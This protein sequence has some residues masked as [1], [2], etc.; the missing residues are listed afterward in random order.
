[1]SE[2][3][4]YPVPN[5]LE[6]V[7][8]DGP[9]TEFLLSDADERLARLADDIALL[10][11]DRVAVLATWADQAD[12]VLWAGRD[13]VAGP[14]TVVL[15]VAEAAGMEAV[16]SVARGICILLDDAEEGAG[17]PAEA[18]RV[19]LR[20]LVFALAQSGKPEAAGLA[21]AD[22]L[23]GLRTSLGFSE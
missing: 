15:E 4:I 13:S 23:H 5:P 19:H 16:G 8:D 17:R 14:A 3:R 18:L 12:D 2:P 1:M 11:A 7:L 21:V 22:A 20:A 6:H 9:R 10:V